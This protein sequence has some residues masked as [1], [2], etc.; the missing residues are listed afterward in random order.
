MSTTAGGIWNLPGAGGS[1]R[2]F[3]SP[4]LAEPRFF[5]TKDVFYLGVTIVLSM[6][7]FC[8]GI[9][10]TFGDAIILF[11]S[12]FSFL[13]P[14]SAVAY[15]GAS[16]V[17][18]YPPNLPYTTAQLS[19]VG[20]TCYIVGTGS[21]RAATMGV[22]V[23]LAWVWPYVVWGNAF[24]DIL[25]FGDVE[26]VR[27]MSLAYA[28]AM[29]AA[30][31]APRVAGRFQ[32]WILALGLGS[33]VGVAG[34]VFQKLGIAANV[35]MVYAPER[36]AERLYLA[37]RQNEV[38]ICIAGGVG[39]I[40]GV[41]TFAYFHLT[42]SKAHSNFLRALG[43]VT[44]VFLILGS[45]T[46][47]ST[48]SRGGLAGLAATLMA[49][50]GWVV[51]LQWR[52][53]RSVRSSAN[54]LLPLGLIA[55]I[56]LLVALLP[57]LGVGRQ[58]GAMQQANRM[59][60]GVGAQGL[61]AG[62]SSVWYDSVNFILSHPIVGMMPGDKYERTSYFG[63]EGI[64]LSH[65]VFL[66][67]ARQYGV[68]GVILYV[69]YFCG[70]TYLLLR[71]RGPVFAGPALLTFIPIFV[72]LNTLSHANHKMFHTYNGMVIGLLAVTASEAAGM[73]AL[74]K[75]LEQI[76]DRKLRSKMRKAVVAASKN[77]AASA[78]PTTAP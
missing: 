25:I 68:L 24:K 72:L 20:W 15:L 35:E 73:R 29:I 42:R 64:P 67:S 55:G 66:D 26:T 77:P 47:L 43:I 12:V 7:T 2:T 59:Q 1:A 48:L 51:Y 75:K 36:G 61:I 45:L 34:Y 33:L 9:Y 39:S 49:W 28:S 19:V 60:G 46:V 23:V 21:F 50:V 38:S 44:G 74:K 63:Y 37:G 5:E 3:P 4:A 14:F 58:L 22:L 17:M 53:R 56:L 52:Y 11:L 27:V 62:R 31:Y 18:P 54:L 78:A 65:N 30:S 32:L 70:P 10:E 6:L 71:Q 13:N 16:Q 8:S 40:L 69:I 76:K 57:G 41:F